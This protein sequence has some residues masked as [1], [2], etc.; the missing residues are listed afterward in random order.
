[1]N[2]RKWIILD[3]DGVI[4]QESENY[5][6]KASD[7]RPL[8]GSLEAIANLNRHGYTVAVVTNQSMIGR[9]LSTEA[10]LAKIHKKMQTALK[11]VGG[12]IERIL[13][14]PHAPEDGCACR[15]PG[16][17]LLERLVEEYAINLQDVP[18]IGDSYRDMQAAKKMGMQPILVLTG[19]G[20]KTLSESDLKYDKQLLI[21]HSLHHAVE[22]I[23]RKTG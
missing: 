8:P 14:C 1:M 12:H 2:E 15:K 13:Y 5:I 11:K 22:A 3:R 18:Y 19:Y 21:F 7:W 4:N 10:N 6:K 17:A 23:L 20:H 16:V 9:G